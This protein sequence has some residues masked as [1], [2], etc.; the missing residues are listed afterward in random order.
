MHFNWHILFHC[1][2]IPES[3][4]LFFY[5]RFHGFLVFFKFFIIA[6]LQVLSI[7]AEQQSD[8]VIH[9]YTH[10]FSHIILHHVPLEIAP[11]EIFIR[12]RKQ[13]VC[14]SICGEKEHTRRAPLWHSGL[15]TQCCHW[16]GSGCCHVVDLI[17]G[18]GK[19]YMLHVW[20]KKREHTRTCYKVREIFI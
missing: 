19:F 14:W 2:H 10:S 12:T 6:D 11:W 4:Y 3:I 7:S 5:L 13:F 16:S 17:P 8:P 20:P 18:H 1:I 9:I 15:R